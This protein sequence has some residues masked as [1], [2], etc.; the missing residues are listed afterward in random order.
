MNGREHAE[1][2]KKMHAE[3]LKKMLDRISK[4]W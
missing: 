4:E 2:L 3:N 1:N